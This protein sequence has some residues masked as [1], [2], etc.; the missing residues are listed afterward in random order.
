MKTKKIETKPVRIPMDVFEALNKKAWEDGEDDRW[1]V[2]RSMLGLELV[3]KPAK[4]VRAARSRFKYDVTELAVGESKT[5]HG[6]S[7]ELAINAVNKY[8]RTRGKVFLNNYVP[9]GVSFTRVV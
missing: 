4:P 8:A 7:M 5:F 2:L 3:H 6:V 9:G 1:N